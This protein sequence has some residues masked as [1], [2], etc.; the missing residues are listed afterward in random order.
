MKPAFSDA[1]FPPP[2]L[3]GSTGLGLG[4]GGGD[5]M[6]L[7]EAFSKPGLPTELADVVLERDVSSE[8]SWEFSLIGRAGT[9]G[10]GLSGKFGPFRVSGGSI[11]LVSVGEGPDEGFVGGGGISAGATLWSL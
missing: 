2:A 11:R 8:G 6:P 3:D 10:F 9:C 5:V 1:I 4:A 7:A